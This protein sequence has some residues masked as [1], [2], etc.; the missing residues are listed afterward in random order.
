ME[1]T[2]RVLSADPQRRYLAKVRWNLELIPWPVAPDAKREEGRVVFLDR[3]SS[4]EGPWRGKP[5][6]PGEAVTIL[7]P[8]DAQILAAGQ[9]Y[10]PR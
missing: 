3:G 1:T 5:L 7:W 10:E 6:H 9:V 8:G 2:D 4:K